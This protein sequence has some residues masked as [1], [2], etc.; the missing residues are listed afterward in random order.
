MA[1]LEIVR[2]SLEAKLPIPS[3]PNLHL[4][5][6]RGESRWSPA[7]RSWEKCC[8]DEQRTDSQAQTKNLAELCA[9]LIDDIYGEL[10]SVRPAIIL[11]S[12]H[13]EECGSLYIQI[14]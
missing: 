4:Y 12:V 14:D 9:L 10:P 7:A 6:A 5:D 13:A 8:V 2:G 3:S 1:S 11:P